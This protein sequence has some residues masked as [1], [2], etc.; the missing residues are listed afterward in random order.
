LLSCFW[1]AL[2]LVAGF[3]ILE[4]RN[5][6]SQ[7]VPSC[8]SL[9][10]GTVANTPDDDT[11]GFNC[12]YLGLPPCKTFVGT[13]LHRENCADLIDLPLCST[14]IPA[15]DVASGVNC[16]KLASDI[17]PVTVAGKV[18]GVDYAVNNKD[19]IRIC[20]TQES[21]DTA[22][23]E[24]CNT[25]EMNDSSNCI[26]YKCHQKT[27]SETPDKNSNCDIIDCKLLTL[28][29]LKVSD[30]RFDDDS[31]QYCDGSTT[32]CYE[33]FNN[34][35]IN[36]TNTLSNNSDNLKYV[37]YRSNNT[38][39]QIHNC[40]PESASCG[41]DDT[42]VFNSTNASY[43]GDTYKA[44]YAQYINAGM[45]VESG[46]CIPLN[47]KPVATRQ[48]VCGFF[49]C[50]QPENSS[51]PEC[52]DPNNPPSNPNLNCDCSVVCPTCPAENGCL[53]GFTR[54]DCSGGYCNKEIDCN[55]AANN[56]QPEC[57]VSDPESNDTDNDLF[58]AWFYRPTPPDTVVNSSSGLINGDIKDILNKDSDSSEPGIQPKFCYRADKTDKDTNDLRKL[59]W[60]TYYNFMW[61][62]YWH[63]LGMQTRSPGICGKD[64]R[65]GFRGN[66]YGYLC[67]TDLN[68]NKNPSN[69]V[70]YIH[71][72]ASANYEPTQPEY[73][74]KA[75]LRY[76][77]SGQIEACGKRECRFN[78]SNTKHTTTNTQWC[79][80]DICREM[81]ISAANID[82]CSM[83]LHS[84]LF[85]NI[86]S[87]PDCIGEDIDGYVR[88]RARKYGRMMCVFI[89]HKGAVA[90]DGKNFDGSETITDKSM[91][92]DNEP[93]ING[94]CTNGYKTI[95]VDGDKDADGKCNGKNTNDDK[96]LATK[97]RT[98]KMIKY[99]GNNR[100]GDKPGYVDM[101]GQF[102]AEQDCAKIPL[103]VGP[104][105]FYNKA[106]VANTRNL[107]EPPLFVLN[108]RTVR[109]GIISES[110]S[111]Q[112]FGDT[113]FYKP[114][115]VVQYGSE[116]QKMSLG[117]GYL[118]QDGTPEDY[119]TSPWEKTITTSINGLEHS[120]EA[121]VQKEYSDNLSQPLLCLYRRIFDQYGQSADPIKSTC[122]NRNKPELRDDT[123]S[124]SKMRILITP[125]AGNIFNRAKLKL[126]LISDYG[127]NNQNNSC[128]S[129][130]ICSQ[131][132]VLENINTDVESCSNDI[133]KY[134]FCSK[135]DTCS[136]LLYE[137][138]NND[139]A[140]NNALASGQPI[141]AFSVIKEN[142]NTSIL[143]NCNKKFGIIDSDSPD[144]LSQISSTAV[145][146]M[147]YQ[148]FQSLF[149]DATK[150]KIDPN[151]Y[152]WF[153]EICIVKGFEDKLKKII[154]YKSTNDALGRCQI[155]DA[156]SVYSNDGIA[157]TNCDAGGKAPYCVCSEFVEGMTLSANQ[158]SRLETSREAGLCIDIPLPNFCPAIDY[159][160]IDSDDDYVAS[161]IVNSRSNASYNDSIGVHTSHQSRTL[162]SPDYHHAEYSSILGGSNNVAGVCN[163]FWKTQTNS[164]GATL[165]PKLNCGT[166]GQ[167]TMVYG[168][169]CERYACPEIYTEFSN[170][171][172]TYINHYADADTS[173]NEGL[174][175][176]YA[177]WHKTTKTT[178]FLGSY[179]SAYQCIA[180]F[181][182]NISGNLPKRYC[183][184]IGAW[185]PI[186]SDV[187]ERITCPAQF[188]G[189]GTLPT[190]IT[191]QA[192]LDAWI[193]NGG[194]E[195]AQTNAS[196]SNSAITPGSTTYGTCKN[197]LGFFKLTSSSSPSRT[198]NYLGNWS[199]VANPCV[200]LDCN[201]I[202]EPAAQNINNGFAI[203]PK[204]TNVPAIVGGFLDVKA[205]SCA[206]GSV[207]NPYAPIDPT[208]GQSTLPN[209]HCSS[210]QIDNGWATVWE[211]PINQCIDKCPSADVDPINGATSEIT[212]TGARNINWSSAEFGQYAYFDGPCSNMNASLFTQGRTNGCYRLR[213]LCGNGSNGFKKGEWGT[214]E[215]MCVANGGIN[216]NATYL[217]DSNPATTGSADALVVNGATSTGV[218]V[219]GYAVKPPSPSPIRQCSYE[220]TNNNGTI[221]SSEKN[222]DKVYWK[223]TNTSTDCT[224]LC[225]IPAVGTIISNSKFTGDAGVTKFPGD[226]V[227][228]ACKS[229][230]GRRVGG[231][232]GDS[233]CGRNASDRS[234]INPSTTCKIDGTWNTVVINDCSQCRDCNSGTLFE[235]NSS[236]SD[237]SR[238]C[239]NYYGC[240]GFRRRA[241]F[242]L[243][244]YDGGSNIDVN[245]SSIPNGSSA[246]GSKTKNGDCSTSATGRS[247]VTCK[248]GMYFAETR[249]S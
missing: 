215:P 55:V 154:A 35:N 168:N 177:L 162:N 40:K 31:K 170:T 158:Q 169:D 220:D 70:G 175:H 61:E 222:I 113:D 160:T 202:V 25:S 230:F 141:G 71:G 4:S 209:R 89:D 63:T 118:G 20:G 205:T 238:K 102:F 77:N 229:N 28:E 87:D 129:D 232:G 223:L 159:T 214:V 18:R 157:S 6:L 235:N 60:G 93:K 128:G 164:S 30:N 248:D 119:P 13:K 24:I 37:A 188:A 167:W 133:E 54:A 161:S 153:N 145:A 242:G 107:F 66:G 236:H 78:V 56:S 217:A 43:K 233:S 155:D 226:T 108:A 186:A 17:S 82:R 80:S 231:T 58:D 67:G 131:E 150:A 247:T 22:A 140:I 132:L 74:I 83:K 181:K 53:A 99:I 5:V 91:C 204:T 239:S 139:I 33:F 96:T 197:N 172:N 137:C 90:Y 146:D 189:D 116:Q 196:R 147:S 84:N 184:Q 73:R 51:K 45:S 1:L 79:G 42:I 245:L 114:E 206:S 94:T 106:T 180:G 38:M 121:F 194:S 211:A 134:K 221:E 75:C 123:G 187:C 124:T 62:Q 135:R 110:F 143:T 57:V 100:G 192:E 195:F 213:R 127:A 125:D 126:K 117:N 9:S 243:N 59:G 176:G 185:E 50:S 88:M 178:D 104:P 103:S 69:D 112:Q 52:T 148:N 241:D 142:C 7:T 218:C 2:I 92:S 19:S 46:L 122:V 183:N 10:S 249:C 165:L 156:R 191:T 95:C 86:D 166:N 39:C 234:S 208:T 27:A 182:I 21:C 105:K 48:Y 115:I 244:G 32:K 72:V 3:Y 98:V 138:V 47:C 44:D 190:A 101:N 198:C 81:K 151:A 64:S 228:L 179:I 15:S 68:I 203:W 16:A 26:K 109:G 224:K 163:G 36:E 152:G 171:N 174:S 111:D 227:N 65:L 97:W 12:Y 200:T 246:S 130:D 225:T 216:N 11:T 212:S 193:D 210:L 240:A 29:E 136:K 8:S 219:V 85:D 41:A 120:A 149:N 49:N 173:G 201:A 23:G 76:A 144:F 34:A 207:P 199:T 237:G 14:I